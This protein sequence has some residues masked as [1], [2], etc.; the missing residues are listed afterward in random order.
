MNS[1]FI[2]QF[3]IFLINPFFAVLFS[4]W[5]IYKGNYDEKTIRYTYIVISAFFALLAYTQKSTALF[6]DTDIVRYY[7]QYQEYASMSFNDP[8]L[9][10][11]LNIM[12]LGF[13][14]ISRTMVM[15][16]GDVRYFSLFWTFLCYILYFLSVDN[17][18]KYRKI[19]LIKSNVLWFLFLS[20][21]A[22][23]LF[24]QIT[25]TYKQSVSSSLFF[26]GFSLYLLGKKRSAIYWILFSLTCHASSILLLFMFI[27]FIISNKYSIPILVCSMVIGYIGIMQILDYILSFLGFDAYFFYLLSGKAEKYGDE[28]SGFSISSIFLLQFMLL[29]ISYLYAKY[30]TERTTENKNFVYAFLCILFINISSPHNFDRYLNLASFPIAVAFIDMLILPPRTKEFRDK[31]ILVFIVGMLFFN[32][33]KTYYRTLD[34]TGYTSSYMDNSIIKIALSPSFV[35]FADE[36]E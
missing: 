25:E 14:I 33:R 32:V 23:L 6:E 29:I 17:Y 24:T 34:K 22:F 31:M 26:Y 9:Y 11:N 28:L 27:P 3:F 12:Y 18:L 30:F 15:I 13:D 10:Y 36:N 1:I 20:I 16:T 35:Y 21:T 4:F 7:N 8:K 19:E 2:L 5:V